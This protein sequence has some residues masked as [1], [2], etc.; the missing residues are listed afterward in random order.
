MFRPAQ[1]CSLLAFSDTLVGLTIFQA[2]RKA[3][4]DVAHIARTITEN[5][6]DEELKT[7]FVESIMD[8]YDFMF[9][10]VFLICG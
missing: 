7:M 1:G 8:M 2:A 3:E 10:F 4:D 6:E 9:R 5:R